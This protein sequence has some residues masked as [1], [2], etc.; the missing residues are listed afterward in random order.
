M[1]FLAPEQRSVRLD[2]HRRAVYELDDRWDVV[3]VSPGGAPRVA[4]TLSTNEVLERTDGDAADHVRAIV[5]YFGD[6]APKA[7][8]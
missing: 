5:E 1:Q 3:A 2:G 4:G 7:S 6:D 8:S